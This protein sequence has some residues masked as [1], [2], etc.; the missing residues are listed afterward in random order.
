[1]SPDSLHGPAR[2]KIDA[3]R[4]EFFRAVH[5]GD[6]DFLRIF[7][8]KQPDA[9]QWRTPGGTPPLVLA[10]GAQNR[11]RWTHPRA[12]GRTEDTIEVLKGFGADINAADAD[13]RTPLLEECH[14]EKR[15]YI[16]E[17]LLKH[18]A[19]ATAA[20]AKG[21]TGLHL[22]ATYNWAAENI[23]VLVQA[24][25]KLDA[26]DWMGNTPLHLAAGDSSFGETPGNE[27][28]VRQLL[29]LGAP[30]LVRNNKMQTP[31]ETALLNGDLAVHGKRLCADLIQAVQDTLPKEPRRKQ[32]E[33]VDEP[34]VKRQG[35][36]PPTPPPGKF[37]LKPPKP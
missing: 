5:G 7:L 2:G 11:D 37:K 16:L 4:E 31:L 8:A 10:L 12:P 13:G 23:R 33:E 22:M 30:L 14:N 3:E 28:N 20:D 29:S 27:D 25:A 21:A 19:D 26:Q 36:K 34:V 6:A 32:V 18:G 15:E 1:M 17:V 24:G 35:P 9:A